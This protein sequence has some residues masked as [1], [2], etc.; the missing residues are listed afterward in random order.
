M[1]IVDTSVLVA[2]A[3]TREASHDACAALLRTEEALVVPAPVVTEACIMPERRLGPLYEARFLAAVAAGG[4]EVEA[5]G[6]A[7]YQRAADLVAT[8]VELGLGFVD[9]AIVVVAERLDTTRIATLNHRD[10]SVV[11]P[12]HAPTLTLLP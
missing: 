1:L 10:F 7:D 11:R 4:L 6:V 9:A 8:Y 5:L 12:A 3:N 2:A